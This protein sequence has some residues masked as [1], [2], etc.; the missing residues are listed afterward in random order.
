MIEDSEPVFFEDKVTDYG[1]WMDGWETR[2][3]RIPGHD[4]AIIKLVA[5]CNIKGILVDTAF[6]TGNFAPRISVQGGNLTGNE[7]SLLPHRQSRLG[8]ASSNE[9]T[10][11]ISRL[12]T[13]LWPQIIAMTHLRPGN[14]E[15]RKNYLPVSSNE[16]FSFIRVNI[17]P[18]AGFARLRV[19][20]NGAPDL[21]KFSDSDVFDLIAMVNGGA[22][23]SYSNAYFSH[24][25]NLIK[26]GRAIKSGDG[27]ETVRRLDRPPILEEDSNGNLQVSGHEWTVIKMSCSGIVDEIFIDTLYFIGNAPYSV[28][29][30]GTI[31][32]SKEALA[33]AKWATILNNEKLSASKDHIYKY[34]KFHAVGPF[35]HVKI[36]IFPDGGMSRVR[37]FGRKAG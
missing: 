22:I 37:V 15:T 18:D 28:R 31:L 11:L 34:D 35:T 30:E 16:A 19:F 24:P 12:G 6:F 5:P 1:K 9:E 25:R 14:E 29:I 2:R 32:S 10:Q 17:Y 4:W 3:K 7:T 26:K 23:V 36:T 8:T 20:G 27:W 33:S 13:E 21:S